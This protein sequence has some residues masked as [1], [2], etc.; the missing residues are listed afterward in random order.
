MFQKN[1]LKWGDNMERY[2][3]KG[4]K[5]VITEFPAVGRI[6][7]EYSIGCAT[8]GVGTCLLKSIVEVHNLA[9]EEEQELMG[10]ISLVIYPERDISIRPA[11][12][13]GS[14]IR[15]REIRYSPP[16]QGLVNE[17]TVIKR[18]LA[19]IPL[20]TEDLDVRRPEDRALV[21]NTIDFIRSYAD[22]YHHAK[23]EEILFKEFDEG[24]EMVRIFNEDHRI[25]RAHV[26]AIIEALETGDDQSI[27]E[28]FAG[29]RELLT[30][31]IR[32]EDEVLY[33]WMDRELSTSQIG[34][35]FARFEEVDERFREVWVKQEA[36][37]QTLEEKYQYAEVR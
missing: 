9:P 25:G 13:Q 33:P 31:H 11:Q 28:H 12:V 7:E 6:L 19:M 26:K 15:T 16:M 8:C 18:V 30:G 24:L 1:T 34:R 32:R 29:Y 37:V 27:R 14:E 21:L 17:H 5:E 4:I 3:N 10:R 23:E 2:L 22:R 35:L 20:I 36:F